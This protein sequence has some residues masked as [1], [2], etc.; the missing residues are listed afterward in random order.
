VFNVSPD[1]WG[2]FN[3]SATNC[4]SILGGTDGI[5]VGN[6]S[7][8]L[9]GQPFFAGH[10]IDFHMETDNELV[11][12]ANLANPSDGTADSGNWEGWGSW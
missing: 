10:Y 12:F 7:A 3:N 8:W 9:L 1:V 2:V 6:V 5:T 11:S 4:T